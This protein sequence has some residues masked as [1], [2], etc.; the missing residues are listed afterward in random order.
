MSS[1]TKRPPKTRTSKKFCGEKFACEGENAEA[2]YEC[3]QCGSFQCSNCER[4][5]H[6]K[7]TKYVIHDRSRLRAPSAEVLCQMSCENKN[8]ADV[9][10][11]NCAMTFC[12]ACNEKVHS[13]GRR[14]SHKRVP[15]KSVG[16]NSSILN[17]AA[18]SAEVYPPIK[19][20]SP[21]GDDDD[22]LTFFTMPQTGL[23]YDV[24]G[25]MEDDHFSSMNSNSSKKSQTP[26][27]TQNIPDVA[28]SIGSELDALDLSEGKVKDDH[29]LKIATGTSPRK[30]SEDSLNNDVFGQCSSFLV[31]D[32]NEN[33]KVM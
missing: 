31:A 18:G 1:R 2:E 11:E 10:C 16:L 27:C 8:F 14:K 22:S 13:Q 25:A 6:E 9:R 17:D 3:E 24:T 23:H 20:S 7:S 21:L 15:F 28:A 26:M 29:Q 32:Q 30:Q 12:N 5:I 4:L 19:P 33:L